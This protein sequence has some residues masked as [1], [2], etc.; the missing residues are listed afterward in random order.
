MSGEPRF[1]QELAT[2]WPYVS[3]VSDYAEEAAEVQRVLEEALP[4][5][6][7]LLELGSGG[8]HN[9]YYLKRRFELTL[10]DRS[11][12]M[13]SVSRRLNPECEHIEADM[14]TLRLDRRFD[15]VFA[16]DAI[17]YMTSEADLAAAIA[18]AARHCRPGGVVLLAPDAV[19]ERFESS[20]ECGGSDREDGA[21]VRYLEWSHDPDPEDD[22]VTTH[23]VFLL[24]EADGTTR[25]VEDTH[26]TGLFS[27]AVWRGHIEAAGL[28]VRVLL[29]ETTEARP[30]RL[31]FLG[32]APAA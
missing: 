7:T 12:A 30:P 23:Y 29:E 15:V 31:F 25:A 13:L 11:E 32:R 16:H 21:G 1:Y 18:T 20:T 24:R 3:P 10:T 2:W 17:E 26:L 14:R 28:Q 4:Q 27:E 5:A 9:A 8:G 22:Q 19:K 6:R